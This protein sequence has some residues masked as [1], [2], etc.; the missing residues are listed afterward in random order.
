MSS[1]AESELAAPRPS[2]IGQSRRS[3][4]FPT[5]RNSVAT[6][7]T[8]RSDHSS[9]PA[10]LRWESFPTARS[11]EHSIDMKATLNAPWTKDTGYSSPCNCG[12]DSH[13]PSPTTIPTAQL[14]LLLTTTCV[15]RFSCY[16]AFQIGTPLHAGPT[17]TSEHSIHATSD[18]RM[19]ASLADASNQQRGVAQAKPRVQR[20]RKSCR[21]LLVHPEGRPTTASNSRQESAA[22]RKLAAPKKS[23]DQAMKRNDQVIRRWTRTPLDNVERIGPVRS[24]W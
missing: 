1:F 4:H 12:R 10:R 8:S 5:N 18:V 23:N 17:R 22:R 21:H 9:V 14:R 3:S 15:N 19:L 11:P 20:T 6:A 7:H 13:R 24:N 2:T 16:S